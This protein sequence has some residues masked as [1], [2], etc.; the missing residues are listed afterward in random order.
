MV[1]WLVRQLNVQTDNKRS[2]PQAAGY[3]EQ[4]QLTVLVQLLVAGAL[5]LD[6][7]ADGA[8]VAQPADG[9]GEITVAPELPT[10]K[11]FLHA[12]TPSE[13]LPRGEAL[14][15]RHQL[16]H[17][18]G[19]HRLHQKMHMIS[20]RADLEKLELIAGLDPQPPS[21]QPLI[22]QA[23]DYPPP[24]LGREH[25]AVEQHRDVVTLVDISAHPQ[26]LRRKRRGMQPKAIQ[27][28]AYLN[29]IYSIYVQFLHRN[30]VYIS[31]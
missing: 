28:I 11:L 24:I 26:P 31:I 18:V 9:A 25:Q 7:G 23:I 17:A 27:E 6:I 13:D 12:G 15:D 5:L 3:S 16:G 20:V 4:C 21:P 14:D 8:L 1:R 10:P 22:T 30:I 29:K 19:W 2:P